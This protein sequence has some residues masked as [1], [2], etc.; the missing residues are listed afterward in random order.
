MIDATI[1]VIYSVAI[2]ICIFNCLLINHMKKNY[3]FIVALLFSF[4]LQSQII[5][6]PD[7]NFKTALINLGVDT[8]NDGE[9]KYIVWYVNYKNNQFNHLS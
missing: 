8:N 4:S 9:L 6:I 3:I 5:D 2:L 7:A 1:H